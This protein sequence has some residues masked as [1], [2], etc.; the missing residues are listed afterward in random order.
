MNRRHDDTPEIFLLAL[1]LCC[2]LAVAGWVF[3]VLYG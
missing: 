3:E 2:A 1:W